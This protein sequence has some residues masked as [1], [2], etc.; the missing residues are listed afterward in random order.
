MDYRV[1]YLADRAV[2]FEFG[3]SISKEISQKVLALHHIL[4]SADMKG[5]VETVPTFRS[6]TV[7]FDPLIL[8]PNEVEDLVAPFISHLSVTK[9]KKHLIEIPCC[10]DRDYAPDLD[11]VAQKTG[12]S[13]EDVIARHQ[14]EIYDVFMLGFLPG[15]G[16]LGVL[17]EALRLPRRTNPRTNV[18]KGSVAIADLMTAIYPSESPGGWHLIGRTPVEIFDKTPLLGAG[19]QI[20]FIRISEQ[21]FEAYA[22]EKTS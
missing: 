17:D 15:F 11:Y 2:T 20:R 5:I 14:D 12:L 13:V 8:F 21:E 4:K 6:I 9:T 16:F 10:Y 18:P 1:L 3:S 7:H 22:Q 19:D